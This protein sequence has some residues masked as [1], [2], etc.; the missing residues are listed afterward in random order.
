VQ[1]RRRLW[2]A[3]IG[4]NSARIAATS[5]RSS[6]DAVH[7]RVD[8]VS[9]TCH[10]ERGRVGRASGQKRDDHRVSGVGEV[11]LTR[12]GLEIRCGGAGRSL[13][14]SPKRGRTAT[15]RYSSSEPGSTG[16]GSGICAITIP[17]GREADSPSSECRPDGQR[18]DPIGPRGTRFQTPY[19]PH[20]RFRAT[21]RSRGFR[22]LAGTSWRADGETRTPDPFITSEVL[23]QLSYVGAAP[24]VSQ[25]VPPRALAEDGSEGAQVNHVAAGAE[26][27]LRS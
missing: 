22:A 3:S 5:P 14:F 16:N 21:S 17:V 24:G 7:G 6:D 27:R 19:G 23:Y 18:G 26:V 11:T 25:D 1:R 15:V 2:S 8:A 9:P 4:M 12:A 10:A 20:L 13:E